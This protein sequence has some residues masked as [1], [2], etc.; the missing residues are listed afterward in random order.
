[1]EGSTSVDGTWTIGRPAKN[2]LSIEYKVVTKSRTS[3]S[4]ADWKIRGDKL[5]LKSGLIPPEVEGGGE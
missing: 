4:H 5:L 2:N 1:M 3:I